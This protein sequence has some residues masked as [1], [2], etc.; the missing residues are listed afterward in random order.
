MRSKTTIL[1]LIHMSTSTH[2]HPIKSHFSDIWPSPLMLSFLTVN[3]TAS[4]HRSYKSSL[5]WWHSVVVKM[6]KCVTVVCRGHPGYTADSN[7][8]SLPQTRT[9][10]DVPL[11]YKT[12]VVVWQYFYDV[13]FICNRYYKCGRFLKWRSLQVILYNLIPRI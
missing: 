7:L 9:K 1:K 4:V 12:H 6:L 13:F 5:F 3:Q 11:I 10:P 8:H 2:L